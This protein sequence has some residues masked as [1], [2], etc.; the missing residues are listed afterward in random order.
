MIGD[1]DAAAVLRGLAASRRVAALGTV[2]DGAPFVSMVPFAVE[3]RMGC[4]VLLV[5]A[6]AAHARNLRSEP[7]VSLLVTGDERAGEPVHDLARATIDGEARVLAGGTGAHAD[8]RTAY[9]LRFP[10]AE[11]LTRLGDFAFVAVQPTGARVVSG[12]AQARS[13]DADAATAALRG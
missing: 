4:V 1:R 12:F 2:R 11:P 5:S 9:L 10:E 6:L 3:R 13:L 7:R 8:A